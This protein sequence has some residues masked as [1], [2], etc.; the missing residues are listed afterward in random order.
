MYTAEEEYNKYICLKH[1]ELVNNEDYDGLNE[2]CTPNFVE[3]NPAWG[4]SSLEQFKQTLKATRQG[5]SDVHVT[6][7]DVTAKGDKVIIR[8]MLSGYHTGY[9]FGQPPTGKRIA[10]E[11]IE[12][13]RMEN[14]KIA[15]RW[16]HADILGLMQQ[17]GVKE[18]PQG[19]AREAVAAG[20][21]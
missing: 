10:W 20:S 17:L 15:E 13:T 8:G 3:H 14:G 5:L 18:L 4:A 16:I 6:P 11:G 7:E 12:I 1:V 9:A 21:R 19:A 2:L